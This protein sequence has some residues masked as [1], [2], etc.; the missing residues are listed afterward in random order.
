VLLCDFADIDAC[1]NNPCS[2]NTALISLYQDLATATCTDNPANSTNNGND[3]A[4]RTC[5]C[6]SSGLA[7]TE[8]TGCTGGLKKTK[9]LVCASLNCHHAV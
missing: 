1:L 6:R 2:Q 3:A 8:G 4:G 5:S 9:N 7:Y